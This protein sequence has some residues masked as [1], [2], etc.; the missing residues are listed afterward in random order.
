MY[1]LHTY[2]AAQTPATIC[3]PTKLLNTV[4]LFSCAHR[5]RGAATTKTVPSPSNVNTS[6]GC[7]EWIVR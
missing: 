6:V 4:V 5:H 7:E 3:T 2:H 1:T